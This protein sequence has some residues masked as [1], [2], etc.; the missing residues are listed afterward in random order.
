M[1][2]IVEF[3][4]KPAY[5]VLRDTVGGLVQ[6]VPDFCQYKG[7][8][9]EVYCDEEGILKGKDLNYEATRAWREY[10]EAKHP[11]MWDPSM[12]HLVGD[13]AIVY[14]GPKK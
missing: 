14:K 10:L 7:R 8:K 13:I 6:P 1:T 12:A 2:K 5:Q 11:G 9:C 3:E 4:K